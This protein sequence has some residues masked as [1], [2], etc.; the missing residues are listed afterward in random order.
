MFD[1][2]TNETEGDGRT[3]DARLEETFED[4]FVEFGVCSTSEETVKFYEKEEVDIF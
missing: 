4:Y 2:T 1:L 3:V